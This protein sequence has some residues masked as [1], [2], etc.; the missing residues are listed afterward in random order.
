MSSLSSRPLCVARTRIFLKFYPFP[1]RCP[2][3]TS[4]FFPKKIVQASNLHDIDACVSSTLPN[5]SSQLDSKLWFFPDISPT[6]FK[7]LLT[8]SSLC[9]LSSA[10][11][12]WYQRQ[13][14][15]KLLKIEPWP[16]VSA[17]SQCKDKTVYG[18]DWSIVIIFFHVKGWLTPNFSPFFV[19]IHSS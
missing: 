8:R 17:G 18:P 14:M 5:K 7:L 10:E 9:A 15:P 6:Q 3:D 2:K 16:L 19:L 12:H 11:G 13:K 4:K 1:V